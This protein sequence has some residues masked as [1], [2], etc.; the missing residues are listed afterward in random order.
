MNRLFNILLRLT[1]LAF[2]FSSDVIA[3]NSSVATE[4]PITCGVN[5][6]HWLYGE[7]VVG[8]N[9]RTAFLEH[10]V[11]QLRD[12]HFDFIR[13]PVGEA[14]LFHEDGTVDTETMML[15]KAKKVTAKKAKKEMNWLNEKPAP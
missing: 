2:M 15:L 1:T 12:W 14:Q 7:D 13:L 5:I 11:R 3:G 9:R 8:G 10:E 6:S 4:F